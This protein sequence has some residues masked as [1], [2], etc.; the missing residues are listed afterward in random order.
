[1][2]GMEWRRHAGFWAA[3]TVAATVVLLLLARPARPEREPIPI[4]GF[5]A[6]H[7]AEQHDVEQH[8]TRFP[9]P[10]RIDADHRFLTAEPH[11]AGTPRDRRLAEWTRDQWR[12]AG[13]DSVEIVEHDVLLPYPGETF[14]ETVGEH[15]WR[16]MLREEDADVGEAHA[17]GEG[18]DPPPIA[19]HAYGASGDV[20]APLV[21]ARNGDKADLD[22]L[23]ARGVDLRGKVLLVRYSVPYSYRGY[24]VFLA[25]QRGAAAILMYADPNDAGSGRGAT[26]PRGPWGPDDRIQR[27][28]VGFDFIA[29][30]DP[31]TPGWASTQGAKRIDRSAA[32]SLPRI[33]SV[34]IS[35]RDAHGLLDTLHH[36]S[37]TRVHVHVVNDE[38][39]RPVWTVIGRITG[40]TYPDQSVIAGN[41]RDAWVYGAVDPSSGSAVLMELARTLG[42]LVRSGA[43]PRR[44]IV[45]ASWDAEEFALTSS[46][47]W[48][49]QHEAELRGSAVAYLNVDAAV[50]GSNFSARAVPSLA[51][52]VSSTAGV[53]D[54][55]I[56]TRIGGGSDYAVFLDF[57]GIPIVDM[58]FEGP[59]GVYHSAYDTHDWVARF[60]DPG[61]LRHAALTRIWATLA[62]R[63]A[64]ADRLPLDEVRYAR[65][66]SDFVDELRRRWSAT[67]P[68][69]ANRQLAAAS[70]AVERFEAAAT[71]FES[72]AHTALALGDRST[73]ERLNAQVMRVEPAFVDGAGL[74][75]RPWYRHLIYAPAFSYE[76]EILPGLSEAVDAGVSARVSAE[77]RRL[78]AALDRAA[79][80][81]SH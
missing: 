26:F 17:D 34:P 41:H 4:D 3:L 70:A 23:A 39:I 21:D 76:A 35:T 52:L 57:I 78:A 32:V 7:L 58:R 72:R 81:L 62:M 20:I 66:I 37:A 73:L 19:F 29:P 42:A 43:R 9:S 61:F 74:A 24:T 54:S 49:E 64:N 46:T 77:D 53:A 16:A 22:A 27:G 5:T 55:T 31:L 13:L 1:M 30:G 80:A 38:A 12:A 50:S 68:R 69:D 48:G 14:V 65:R 47:E 15:P 33:I 11:M 59:Y 40:S 36:G 56:G 18:G 10:R 2:R 63:L 28:G 51:R 79:D 6:D 25:Q 44:S 67:A 60:A 75:G 45:L 8:I 71:A